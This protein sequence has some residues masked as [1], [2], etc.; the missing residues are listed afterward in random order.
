[1][2]I[3]NKKLI[4]YREP[5]RSKDT[6]YSEE[7]DKNGKTIWIDTIAFRN[8]IKIKKQEETILLPKKIQNLIPKWE[9]KIDRIKDNEQ[10]IRNFKSHEIKYVTVR[11]I[12]RNKM[13][14]IFPKI[15]KNNQRENANEILY[16]VSSV[17]IKDLESTGCLYSDCEGLAC[18]RN[19]MYFL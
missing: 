4:F 19:R 10:R 5:K 15:F 14:S 3:K 1:M 13:Y 7:I 6:W 16:S 12:Y 11:F 9:R 8:P 17:I 2:K 18:R